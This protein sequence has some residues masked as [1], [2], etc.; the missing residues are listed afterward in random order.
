MVSIHHLCPCG[1]DFVQIMAAASP[2]AGSDNDGSKQPGEEDPASHFSFLKEQ[3]EEMRKQQHQ[4]RTTCLDSLPWEVWLQV[5]G[6]LDSPRDLAS[7]ALACRYCNALVSHPLLWK[8]LCFTATH[9]FFSVQSIQQHSYYIQN[10]VSF[11][12]IHGSSS[13]QRKSWIKPSTMPLVLEQVGR[14]SSNKPFW[15]NAP[16]GPG[17]ESLQCV[18][19]FN[20]TTFYG[21]W[22][23]RCSHT[24]L[25]FNS[26]NI[27]THVFEGHTS[28]VSRV[29]YSSNVLVS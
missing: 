2:S 25:N 15:W 7:L 24:P 3:G 13:S 20:A 28:D 16:K 12:A 5:L 11:S 9:R 6:F 23:S 19:L 22:N 21:W 27:Q 18:Q 14:L 10:K 8:G 29:R 26:Q 4:E 1:C 17:W